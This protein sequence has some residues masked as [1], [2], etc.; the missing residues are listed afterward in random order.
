ADRDSAARPTCWP[1][2]RWRRCRTMSWTRSMPRRSGPRPRAEGCCGLLPFGVP[3]EGE[4]WDMVAGAWGSWIRSL[5]REGVEHE[6]HPGD[7]GGL[8]GIDVRG[9]PEDRI[10]LRGPL[11]PEELVH[12]GERAPVVA[13]HVLE[14]KP[15]EL[16]PDR[17]VEPR[18]VLGAQHPRHVH[19]VVA[20]A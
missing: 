2:R 19:R 4:V 7:L 9:E 8:L 16:D 13:D 11:G 12:H 17:G 14:E 5:W 6:L 20:A 15:V 18:E 10:V 1:A 3:V